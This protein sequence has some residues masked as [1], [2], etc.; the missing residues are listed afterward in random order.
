MKKTDGS[1]NA[2]S[3]AQETGSSNLVDSGP[4]FDNVLRIPLNTQVIGF[5]RGLMIYHIP[6]NIQSSQSSHTVTSQ[7]VLLPQD[8]NP[9]NPVRNDLTVLQAD[10]SLQK[11]STWRT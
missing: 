8:E 6:Q 7:G 1:N 2:S 3:D 10:D 5:L 11:L 4:N 9:P